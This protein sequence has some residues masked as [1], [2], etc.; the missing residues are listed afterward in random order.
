M[1]AGNS[2]SG[3]SAATVA[4]AVQEMLGKAVCELPKDAVRALEKAH[5]GETDKVAKAQLALILKNI[6]LAAKKKAPMCQDTGT[7][8]FYVRGERLGKEV[9]DG[10]RDGVRKA[11][12]SVP[13]RPNSVDPIS[14]KNLG[15]EPIINYEVADV[16]KGCVEISVIPKGAGCE[17]MSALAMLTPADG[18]D[19]AKK[20]I[21][22][23]VAQ[24]G[25]NA[26]PPLTIGIGIGGTSEQAAELA[27]KAFLSPLDEHNKDK[28][29]AELE[30]ELLAAINALELGTMGLGGNTTALAVKI[31]MAPTHTASLPVALNMQ[32]WAQRKATVKICGD[33]IE[34]L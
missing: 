27:K 29:L 4:K 14:R 24:K 19:G 32:C 9:A 12:E 20:F 16:G 3:P 10:V 25:K 2:E 22:R 11:T 13:L 15:N 33:E 6:G 28:R 30:A 18:I 31:N 23:T 8:T 5:D 34:I 7:L 21:L 1:K 26:C 17:N